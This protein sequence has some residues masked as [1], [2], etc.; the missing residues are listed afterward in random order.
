[1][2]R[3]LTREGPPLEQLLR[4][5]ADVPADFLAE[6]RVGTQ[7]QVHVAAVVG[8]LVALLGA[9]PSANALARFGGAT[10]NTPSSLPRGALAVTLLLCWLYA[11]AGFAET[12]TALDQLPALL[13][14]TARELGMIPARRFVDDPDRREELVRVALAAFGLRPAGESRAQ[15]EDRLAS[16]SSVERA[17]VVAAARDAELRARAIREALQ[18]KAAEESADK[19]TRE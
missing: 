12:W 13:G 15:A 8:D 3:E 6:P 4:R 9:R 10:T 11:D 16:V 1:M 19:W 5:L 7:G 14:D 17:R 18:R 2:P